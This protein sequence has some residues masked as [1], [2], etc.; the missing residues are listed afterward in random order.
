MPA[1]NRRDRPQAASA[2]R[3][4]AIS[5]YRDTG[6][7]H[8]SEGRESVEGSLAPLRLGLRGATR[9]GSAC[10]QIRWYRAESRTRTM[11]LPCPHARKGNA[12]PSPSP[13]SLLEFRRFVRPTLLRSAAV[14]GSVSPRG[15]QLQRLVGHRLVKLKAPFWIRRTFSAF[16]SRDGECPASSPNVPRGTAELPAIRQPHATERRSS[17]NHL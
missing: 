17:V 9:R 2:H 4:T 6:Q 13:T 8:R 12:T 10:V 5:R 1:L 16:R 15:R 3:T 14:P 7:K 11:S